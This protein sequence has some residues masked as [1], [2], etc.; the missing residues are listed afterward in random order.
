MANENP[1]AN[2]KQSL[3]LKPKTIAIQAFNYKGLEDLK[4]LIDFVGSTP[5][6]DVDK[7]GQPILLYK[8]NVLKENSIIMRNS[9]GEV[10]NVLTYPDAAEVFDISAQSEFK[11]EHKNKVQDKPPRKKVK[12]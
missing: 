10:T 8:K 3:I 7:S 5:K 6:I 2:A 11:P 4:N 12:K 9:F 1:F